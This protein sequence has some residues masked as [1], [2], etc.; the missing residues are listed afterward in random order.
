MVEGIQRPVYTPQTQPQQEAPKSDHHQAPDAADQAQRTAQEAQQQAQQQAQQD[1]AKEAVKQGLRESQDAQAAARLDLLQQ[2][3]KA[4]EKLQSQL[5][6][7]VQVVETVVQEGVE[8]FYTP[9]IDRGAGA[10]TQ[11]HGQGFTPKEQQMVR[12]FIRQLKHLVGEQGLEFAHAFNHLKAQQ[13][14]EFWKQLNQVLQKGMAAGAQNLTPEQLAAKLKAAGQLGAAEG[15]AG[16][17]VLRGELG[18]GPGAALAEVIR[19]ETNPVVHTEAM[20]AALALLKQEG[21]EKA[22]RELVQYLRHRWKMSEREMQRFLHGYPV[23]YFQGPAVQ[24][25]FKSINTPWYPLIALVTIPIAKLLGMDWGLA[26]F[27]G[28]LLTVVMFLVA[29]L[30]RSTD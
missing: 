26:V 11:D 16:K 10:F 7:F 17:E 12:E 15:E 4:K 22:H 27:G 21:M 13:G 5:N 28:V 18:R 19:A 29:Y 8:G 14:G 3:Q 30:N 2:F 25:K 20:L 6:E 1:Q 24:E 23:T 9:N